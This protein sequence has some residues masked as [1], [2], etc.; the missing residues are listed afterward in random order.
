MRLHFSVFEKVCL[1]CYVVAHPNRRP[2]DR[3]PASYAGQLIIEAPERRAA[4]TAQSGTKWTSHPAFTNNHL[5]RFIA[6]AVRPL[7]KSAISAT[8]FAKTSW[9]LSFRSSLFA[10][11]I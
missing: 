9:P 6:T 8:T 7:M 3:K 4:S 10:V 1:D 5:R 11:D 2:F